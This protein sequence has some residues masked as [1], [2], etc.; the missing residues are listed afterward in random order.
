ARPPVQEV[1]TAGQQDDRS[2][3][4]PGHQGDLPA[5]ERV[6][7]LAPEIDREVGIAGPKVFREL[8]CRHVER[9]E[10]HVEEGEGGSKVPVEPLV[11]RGVVPAVEHGAGEEVAEWPE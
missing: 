5:P 4:A 10:D 11:L 7:E 2:Q 6:K 8:A 3:S 1:Q 9:A